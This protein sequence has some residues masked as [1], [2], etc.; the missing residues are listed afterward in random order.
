M[1]VCMYVC[2]LCTVHIHVQNQFYHER[3]SMRQFYHIRCGRCR[4]VNA[5]KGRR[6]R[7]QSKTWH[8]AIHNACHHTRTPPLKQGLGG[9]E[10][11]R[12]EVRPI[13]VSHEPRS[14]N[15]YHERHSMRQFYHIRCGRCRQVNASKGRRMRSQSKTWHAAIHNACHHTRTPPMF[16]QANMENWQNAEETL[17]SQIAAVKKIINTTRRI[18]KSIGSNITKPFRVRLSEM[19]PELF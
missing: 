11:L 12:G 10:D 4:Q 6:M 15:T 5:S 19:G 13:H 14:K 8:A 3:H 7:S 17:R 9:W 2:I 1:F 16:Q 18:N